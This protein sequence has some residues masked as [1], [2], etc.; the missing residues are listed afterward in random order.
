MIKMEELTLS[1]LHQEIF[2]TSMTKE[3]INTRNI[4]LS[5]QKALNGAI[6]KNMRAIFVDW[7]DEQITIYFV[8]DG[9]ISEDDIEEASCVETEFSCYLGDPSFKTRFST[10]CIRSDVPE[11][12]PDFG[13]ECVFKRKE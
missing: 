10:E 2:E 3:F 7:D 12:I 8:F 9:E 11:P 5:F 6:T 1:Q 13:K 4:L